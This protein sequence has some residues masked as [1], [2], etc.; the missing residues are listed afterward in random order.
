MTPHLTT[1]SF[2]ICLPSK[3]PAKALGK[4]WTLLKL[5]GEVP[6]K[7]W[8]LISVLTGEVPGRPRTEQSCPQAVMVGKRG[9]RVGSGVH[10]GSGRGLQQRKT[11]AF[12]GS[13]KELL[14][15]RGNLGGVT[16]FTLPGEG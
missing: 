6:L 12:R 2:K 1:F 9:G 15:E 16:G 7:K 10:R 14:C 3:S 5:G 11:K 13:S 4:G 8:I